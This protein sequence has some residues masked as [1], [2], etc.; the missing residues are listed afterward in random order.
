MSERRS[1]REGAIDEVTA[2][3]GR[4]QVMTGPALIVPYVQR[5]V[6]LDNKGQKVVR[7]QTHHLTLLPET[8]SI[9]GEIESE[10]RHRGIF[11]VP[12][13]R[14]KLEVSGRFVKPDLSEYRAG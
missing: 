13:Y 2:K 9:R 4:L 10:V 8:L 11:S 5:R 1:R 6:E 14:L 12:V 7:E 3:W